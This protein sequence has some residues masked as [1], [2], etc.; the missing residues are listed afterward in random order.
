MVEYKYT[1]RTNEYKITKK[2]FETIVTSDGDREWYLDGKLHRED[3]PAVESGISKNLWYL[4][5]VRLF[6]PQ[7]RL[8]KEILNCSKEELVLKVALKHPFNEIVMQR[9]MNIGYRPSSS[10]EYPIPKYVEE[11]M[12]RDLY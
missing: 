7:I 10:R 12:S 1:D 4:H 5:G 6:E 2:G 8:L 9:L 11:M 3:G